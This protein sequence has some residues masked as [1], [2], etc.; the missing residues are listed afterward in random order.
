MEHLDIF[1]IL[2]Q[3]DRKLFSKLESNPCHPLYPILP[4]VKESSKNLRA[5]TLKR[6]KVNTERF[7]N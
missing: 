7:R 2:E 4:Q 1:S 6:P 3:Y 5:Q